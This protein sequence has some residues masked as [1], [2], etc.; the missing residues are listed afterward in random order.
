LRIY[1]NGL[2]IGLLLIGSPA[3]AANQDL[4]E[5]DGQKVVAMVNDDPITLEELDRAIAASR[6]FV[7]IGCSSRG[8]GLGSFQGTFFPIT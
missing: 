1:C 7:A 6:G 3:L 4:P 2:L 8:T 5:V